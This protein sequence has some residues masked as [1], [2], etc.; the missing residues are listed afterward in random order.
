MPTP[1]QHTASSETILSDYLSS[2]PDISTMLKNPSRAETVLQA[3]ERFFE[4]GTASEALRPVVCASWERCR[5]HG[6]APGRLETQ[7]E[8][9]SVL[10]EA[11]RSRHHL[12]EAA[13]P[14]LRFV[15]ATLGDAPH[16]LLLAGNDGII[17]R[18]FTDSEQDPAQLKKQNVFEGASRREEDVGTGVVGTALA[19]QQ[20]VV[21]IG[22]EHFAESY[23]DR[24]S[25]GVPLRASDGA[26]AG[27]L[28]LS[29]PTQA[30]SP[31]TWGWMLSI[32]QATE[33]RL[34][35]AAPEN[36]SVHHVFGNDAHPLGAVLDA[37]ELLAEQP[38]LSP[39][40]ARLLQSAQ[41]ETNAAEQRLRS[42]ISGLRHANSNKE[43]FLATLAHEMAGPL[44]GLR[45]S[46][47]LLRIKAEDPKSVRRLQERAER[48]T[49]QLH[50]QIED[51]RDVSSINQGRLVLEEHDQV[52]ISAVLDRA[53]ETV[54]PLIEKKHHQLHVE[55]AD[56]RMTV[57]GDLNRLVQVFSN[58]LVNAAKYTEPEG[59]I[60]LTA[61]RADNQIV[62]TVR[63]N[64]TGIHPDLLPHIFSLFTQE[65]RHN[66]KGLGIGLNLVRHLVEMHG[67]RVEAYSD[68]PDQGSEIVVEM[69]AA[70]PS[71]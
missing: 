61:E 43:R 6:L 4:E 53:L 8:D 25:I 40:Q 15:H 66:Q 10:R 70:A 54:D 50:R 11:R 21:L 37:L 27:V 42:M 41:E 49:G 34:H 68:G 12:L 22:P 3:R 48:L 47:D 17:L 38:D 23:L 39:A 7:E 28:G 71:S 32:G 1:S 16:L 33:A 56:E 9:V 57:E 35:E 13:E 67:G 64:G 2:A 20:P 60:W 24:A 59:T 31:H 44:S 26:L 58:L 52:P 30:I 55:I 51:L 45:M 29:V 46:L 36:D 69:P 18:L 19:E 14:L 62:V 63:D 5:T 65:E